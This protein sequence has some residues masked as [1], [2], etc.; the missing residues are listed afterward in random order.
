MDKIKRILIVCAGLVVIAAGCTHADCAEAK[1]EEKT[2][3]GFRLVDVSTLNHI[4][5][6]EHME[7]GVHYVV[8]AGADKGGI[9]VMLNPDGTPY[10]GE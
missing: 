8:Y 4:R 7:T 5:E 6:Y 1:T 10:T 9:C 3:E 2:E